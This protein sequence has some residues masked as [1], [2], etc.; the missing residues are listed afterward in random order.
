MDQQAAEQI[1]QLFHRTTRV[2]DLVEP[3]FPPPPDS[4]VI[5]DQD[6]APQAYA[7]AANLG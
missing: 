6:G 1:E 7:Q 5:Y 4:V 3:A 2:W